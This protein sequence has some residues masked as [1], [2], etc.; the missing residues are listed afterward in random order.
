MESKIRVEHDFGTGQTWIQFYVSTISRDNTQP[1]LRDLALKTFIEKASDSGSEL[2][3]T[4]PPNNSDNSVAQIMVRPKP[5]YKIWE[6]S[7]ELEGFLRSQNIS[8]EK[9]DGSF[10]LDS[11][12]HDPFLVGAGYGRYQAAVEWNSKPVIGS[13]PINWVGCNA[14][15]LA[16]NDPKGIYKKGMKY[17]LEVATGINHVIHVRMA[18]LG[19]VRPEG[20]RKL[21]V[22]LKTF[23][24]VWKIN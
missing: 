17:N 4:Y 11:N 23:S 7:E 21:Y 15:Y 24:S 3:L 6:N 1:E 14:T 8:Y 10:V 18:E 2:Y 13:E 12:S 9:I 5:G 22:D 19:P 20:N 16:E